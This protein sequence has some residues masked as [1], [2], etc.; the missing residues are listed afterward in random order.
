LAKA[1]TRQD[2]SDNYFGSPERCRYTENKPSVVL[3][4]RRVPFQGNSLVMWKALSLAQIKQ[5]L[6]TALA[7]TDG[8]SVMEGVAGLKSVLMK[9]AFLVR[10][11]HTPCLPLILDRGIMICMQL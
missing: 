6:Q 5:V 11:F 3:V 2:G 1:Q 9:R 10:A 7:P 8:W 4:F